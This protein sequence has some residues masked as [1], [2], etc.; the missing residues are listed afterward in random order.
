[1]GCL[2]GTPEQGGSA[3]HFISERLE[4]LGHREEGVVPVA[5]KV[6]GIASGSEARGELS[7]VGIEVREGSQDVLEPDGRRLLTLFCI[8]G[9]T[10]NMRHGRK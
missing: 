4:E 10:A 8:F 1:V 5:G 9:T 6:C 7:S 2:P 3:A